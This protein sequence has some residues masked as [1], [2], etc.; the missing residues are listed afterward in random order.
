[1]AEP[2]N[3]SSNLN[4]AEKAAVLMMALGEADAAEVIKF[5]SPREVNRLSGAIARL[6]KV[7]KTA[8]ED[9]MGEFVARIRDQT[10]IGLGVTE[11]LRNALGRA[12]GDERASA[13]LE[14]IM[15]GGDSAGIEAVKWEDPRVVAEMIR[16]EHP[17][18]IAMILAYVEPEQAQDVMQAL[19]DGVIEQ[20]IPRLA[21]LEVIPPSA[22]RE[23][24]EALED[25]LA[26][27]S[28]QVRLSNV[29]GIK[30]AAEIL[31]RFEAS[32]AQSVL[33]RIK[34]MDA[35][36][37]QRIYDNMFVFHD[38]LEVDDRSIRTLL[39]EINQALLVPAL[40]GVDAALRE[41]VT[42]NMSQRAAESLNEE[43][44]A[45]GPVRVAEV[46]A[47]QK[48][49]ITIAKR[50]EQEG[51]IILRTDAKDLVA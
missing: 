14:R 30:A 44:E 16:E 49:I 45:K 27:E 20:V 13:L 31:N 28:Q 7:P 6:N 51:R 2:I 4:P 34:S 42:R 32:R 22:V 47:A 9:V 12:L 36:L 8:V 37:S 46:E 15:N 24:N 17:Q 10:A 33:E 41:K 39:Q 43:I 23:L 18:I 35:D 3:G 19:P 26:G 5:L 11:Y 40:K 38:L 50:L 1:M 29:G 25:Q 48:E 21:T